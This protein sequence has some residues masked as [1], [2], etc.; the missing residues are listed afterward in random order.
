M[1]T[2]PP[3][4]FTFSGLSFSWRVT[5]I[6]ATENASFS[7][8]RS[9]SLSRSHPVF[10]SS[11]STASTGAIITHLGSTP[12]T[13]CATMRAIGVFPRRDALRSLVTITAAAPSFVPGAFPAVTVPSFLNAGFSFASASREV[14]SRGDSSYFTTRGSPFF[15]G[16][17]IG[18]I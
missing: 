18:R 6:A 12:L 7:S 9:T 4:T 5:A 16:T 2:A 14:S 15:C 13:A 17:S 8:M 10:L 1:A 11:F 3:F